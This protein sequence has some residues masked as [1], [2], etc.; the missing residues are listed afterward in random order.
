MFPTVSERCL[1]FML[2]EQGFNYNA[3][4]YWEGWEPIRAYLETEMNKCGGAKNWKAALGNQM[5]KHY[6]TRSQWR[7]PTEEAYKKLQAFANGDAFKREYDELKREFYAT[8]AHFDNTHDLMTDVWEFP[9]VTGEDRHGHATPKPVA[10]MA[11]CIKS[12]APERGVVV[13]PFLGSGSTLIAAEQLDRKCYGMEI[14]PQY[15][16]VIVARWEK[17]TGKK[18]KLEMV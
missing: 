8:R 15:C 2:G 7:F 11:R 5:G 14:S 4:N 9:R 17:L 12:S 10:M 13:E 16:D 1:F 18:A 3:D 6:F